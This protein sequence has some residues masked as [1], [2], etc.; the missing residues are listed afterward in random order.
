[1]RRVLVSL[2]LLLAACAPEG[3]SSLES[4]PT[5]TCASGAQWTQGDHESSLMHPGKA[6]ASCHA[7]RGEGPRFTVAGTVYGAAGQA[8]D[9]AGVQGVTVEIT[10]AQ[11]AVTTLTSNA[12]G[13]FFTEKSVAMPYTARVLTATGE[14]KM[15]GAQSNGDCA[16]C[17]TAT[18]TGGAP[19]RVLAP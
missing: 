19:G 12:A 13:N 17:H 11:G 1:M 18:G 4:V 7:S 16:A 8:D 10:D 2:P 3:S 6:C 14:R 15:F 9:C 5:T